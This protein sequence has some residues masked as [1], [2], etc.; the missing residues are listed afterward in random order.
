[1]VGILNEEAARRFW[2]DE[3]PIG[4][5]LAIG[6]GPDA[7]RLTIVGVIASARHD[8][9]NQPHK[10]EL[11]APQAQFPTRVMTLVLE[12]S[13]GVPALAAAYRRALRDVDP[14]VPASTLEPLEQSVGDAVALPRLYATLVGIFA[15]CA[16]LLAAVGVYGVMAYT[17]AQ[18]RREIGVRLALGA[19][20]AGIRRLV[21]GRGAR[22]AL[23]GLG[24][25]LVAALALGRVIERL[26][27]GVTSFDV[28]T[29]VAV[30]VVLGVVTLVASW[31]PAR[32]AMRL[33]PVSAI[34]E[35]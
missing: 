5:T 12:P 13:R 3:N 29:L 25:G 4:R 26:L 19:D 15:A 2:P 27:F 23:I 8:G 21:I 30:P 35:E 16:L 32:R 1:M 33:D 17:V 11:F 22:L 7:D 34:R 31:V 6:T 9:P 10:A 14:L 28:P 18:R 20:P 24:G